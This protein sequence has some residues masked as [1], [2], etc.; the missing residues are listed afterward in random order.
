[1]TIFCNNMAYDNSTH[2]LRNLGMHCNLSRPSTKVLG[3]FKSQVDRKFR[4]IITNWSHGNTHTHTCTWKKKEGICICMHIHDIDWGE[5]SKIF[6]RVIRWATNTSQ[7]SVQRNKDVRWELDP[8]QFFI[9]VCVC[10]ENV[11]DTKYTTE[12][13]SLESRHETKYTK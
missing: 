3:E 7:S 11:R 10:H 8:R 1:M 12:M 6:T 4:M 5:E 13:H 2:N 9:R